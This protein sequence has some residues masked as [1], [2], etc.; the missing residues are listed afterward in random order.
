[1]R[2]GLLCAEADIC[3]PKT[4]FLSFKKHVSKNPDW[5]MLGAGLH[6]GG[7]DTGFCVWAELELISSSRFEG[8][9]LARVV[10]ESDPHR[11]PNTPPASPRSFPL[12]CDA[13]G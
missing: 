1:M 7:G 8:S 3:P 9:D 10:L 4:L 2:G 5:T 11:R 12:A 13:S 6:G